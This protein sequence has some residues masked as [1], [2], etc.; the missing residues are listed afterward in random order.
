VAVA[1]DKEEGRDRDWQEQ[2]QKSVGVEQH[3]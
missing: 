3:R 1:G 2:Q